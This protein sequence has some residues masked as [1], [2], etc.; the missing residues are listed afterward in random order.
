MTWPK[1]EAQ[2][3]INVGDAAYDPQFPYGW[4]LTTLKKPPAGGGP[5][6]AALA[7]RVAEKARLGKNPAG[8]AIVDQVRLLVQRKINGKFTRAVYKPFAEA[9][10]LL[11]TGDLTGAVDRLRTAYRAAR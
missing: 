2:L 4:G 7:A 3:P 9:D 10:H 8:K 11:L 1:A 6:L 5:V